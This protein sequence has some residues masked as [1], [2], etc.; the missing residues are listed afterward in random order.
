MA[1]FALM[2]RRAA[3]VVTVTTWT[4]ATTGLM[5]AMVNDASIEFGSS[6]FAT[7][8]AVSKSMTGLTINGNGNLGY[9][10]SGAS[11]YQCLKFGSS[12]SVTITDIVIQNCYV[13]GFVSAPHAVSCQLELSSPFVNM[14]FFHPSQPS[15][16]WGRCFLRHRQRGV[17][18]GGQLRGFQQHGALQRRLSVP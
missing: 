2:V 5:D 12:A 15:S 3:A 7:S 6:I 18:F 16:G 9:V 11:D 4:G 13:N 17:N 8:S 1:I 10:L 14:F